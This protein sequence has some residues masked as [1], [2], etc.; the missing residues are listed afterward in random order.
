MACP[1][2]RHSPAVQNGGGAA[3]KRSLTTRQSSMQIP[4]DDVE[5]DKDTLNQKNLNEA[6]LILTEPP[7]S[8]NILP[9]FIKPRIKCKPC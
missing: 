3:L 5:E 1:F 4:N 7:V 2:S 8:S 9:L 6:I